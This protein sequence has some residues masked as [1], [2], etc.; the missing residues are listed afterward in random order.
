[1]DQNIL[2]LSCDLKRNFLEF[3][4]CHRELSFV[5]TPCPRRT[6]SHQCNGAANNVKSAT[7]R[8][9]IRAIQSHSKLCI[10]C[11]LGLK[12]YQLKKARP[13]KTSPQGNNT[14]LQIHFSVAIGFGGQAKKWGYLY[15]GARIW[16]G[17]ATIGLSVD[18]IVGAC[19]GDLLCLE[20]VV[21]SECYGCE[22]GMISGISLD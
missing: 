18:C 10:D 11:R 2:S 4:S 6:Y 19:H 16:H 17:H 8:T 13:I 1:M 7:L 9:Q 3:C 15:G 22:S 12:K 21:V 5:V 20:S 14:S